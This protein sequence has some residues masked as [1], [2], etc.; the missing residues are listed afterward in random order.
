MFGPFRELEHPSQ[1]RRG[2]NL[3]SRPAPLPLA[4]RESPRPDEKGGSLPLNKTR[5]WRAAL[6]ALALAVGIVSLPEAEG[7]APAGAVAIYPTDCVQCKV[8]SYGPG[9]DFVLKA[10]TFQDVSIKPKRG[11]AFYGEAGTILDGGGWVDQAFYHTGSGARPDDV[12]I[13][14]LDANNKMVIRNYDTGGDLHAGTFATRGAQGWVLRYLDVSGAYAYG[15][16]LGER[17]VVE[18]SDIHDNGTLGIGGRCN[19]CRIE[20]NTVHR[21]NL[22]GRG[23]LYD[24]AGGIKIT[25][26]YGVTIRGNKVHDNNGAGVWVDINSRRI[27]VVGNTVKANA[28]AA[29]WYEVS[30]DGTI[31]DNWTEASQA[32]APADSFLYADIQVDD[33]QNVTI[34][35]NTS[36]YPKRDHIGVRHTNR[37]DAGGPTDKVYVYGNRSVGPGRT[38]GARCCGADTGMFSRDIRF[39][40]NRYEGHGT[41]IWKDYWT[42][43]FAGWQGTQYGGGHDLSGSSK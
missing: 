11:M 33:S 19:F 21:N 38:G 20:S 6:V 15:V 2:A 36:W 23:Q 43:T 26:A 8:D 3:G 17:M 29:I 7:A 5:A 24:E 14:G 41:F 12:R 1:G 9:T 35:R 42:L 28:L 4:S 10:G 13:E 31:I 25:N 30:F 39:Q 22:G 32:K 34:A 18:S 40:D 37:T 16:H 27:D